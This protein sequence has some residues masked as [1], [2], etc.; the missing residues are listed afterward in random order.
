M[1]RNTLRRKLKTRYAAFYHA[2]AAL[3]NVD[4]DGTHRCMITCMRPAARP[5]L[6]T[7]Y[8]TLPN[9]FPFA[10][11]YITYSGTMN[12]SCVTSFDVVGVLRLNVMHITEV[13]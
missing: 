9:H 2:I 13:P 3:H 7:R 1:T 11:W 4:C 10:D 5:L 12:T 6:G 8:A